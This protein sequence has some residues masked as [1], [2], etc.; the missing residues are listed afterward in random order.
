MLF[1]NNKIRFERILIVFLAMLFLLFMT[2]SV[3]ASENVSYDMNISD[4]YDIENN[5]GYVLNEND[6][7][8][9]NSTQYYGEDRVYESTHV[10]YSSSCQKFTSGKIEYNVKLYDFVR[11]GGVRYIEPKY[12]SI[13]KLKV[14][15]GNHYKNYQARVS[16]DGI[17]HIKIP[18]LNIGLHKVEIYHDNVKKGS[19]SIKIIKSVAKVYGPAKFI[20]YGK[21]AYMRV[22][23]SYGRIVKNVLLKVNVSTGNKVKT[24]RIRTDNGGFASFK[25]D[26]LSY[27]R[28][29]I[30]ITTADSRYV[31][32]KATKILVKKTVQK[33]PKKLYAIAN[34]VTNQYKHNAYFEIRV[35]DCYYFA[36]KNLVLKMKIFTD[37]KY[38]TV[39]LK[40]NS[41]GIAR[42]NTKALSIGSHKIDISNVNKKYI[43]NKYSK[44]I[45]KRNIGFKIEPTKLKL[46]T[47]SPNHYIKLTWMSKPGSTYQI[48][49]KSD[50]DYHIVSTV[51]AKSENQ[52]FME[53]VDN[54]ILAT[55][56]VRELITNGNK[57]I[58]GSWDMGGLKMIDSPHVD[59]DFQNL[60]AKIS[61][62]AIGGAT[63]YKIL[64]KI[65]F[66]GEYSCIATV[67]SKKLTYTDWYY[68]SPDKLSQLLNKETF[69]DPNS[70]NLFY[71]VR[72]CKIQKINDVQKSSMGLY[73]KDGDFHL[74]SPTI[75]HI[76]ENNITWGEVLNA[77]G[78][79][80]LKKDN[81]NGLWEKIAEVN[82]TNSVV[83]SFEIGEVD[84]DAYYSV[85]AFS[86]KNG[87]LIR[88]G[89]DKGFT[90]KYFSHNSTNKILFI[91]DSITHGSPYRYLYELS[92][93]FSFPYRVSQLTGCTFY[94]PSVAGSTYHDLGIKSDGSNV[95][96]RCSIPREVMDP[97]SI[98]QLPARWKKEGTAKNSEGISH[99]KLSDYNIVVLSAG[100][101]DY[102][103]NSKLG[104]INT[105]DTFYFN[106][107][108]NYI[109]NLIKNASKY[110]VSMGLSPIKVVFMDLFLS[111]L[112]KPY[113]TPI[114]RD[115]SPNSMGLTLV[116]YQKELD[117]QFYKWSKSDLE[118]FKFKT[119]SYNIVNGNN[120][121]HTTADNQHF[122]KF[123]YGQY[124][125]ELTKFLVENVFA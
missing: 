51:I 94:N 66:E 81:E 48:L 88:S 3:C 123:T 19:S 55:Y 26:G 80:I 52:F 41:K 93:I 83:Q 79:Y 24:Y 59:V 125:N 61:W 73:L 23:D 54:K 58:V 49:K 6:L 102:S 98:G 22:I 13:I 20:K 37:N 42:Y 32:Y 57:N 117:K 16:D 110:R 10:K 85:Q 8:E 14:Y 36:V 4:S 2:G 84:N 47:Y 120:Y 100:L 114:N 75:V 97:I 109:M 92:G 17:A 76:K 11:Y 28:H 56:S 46:L 1:G 33:H 12:G 107:G 106:G 27:G 91:G 96:K 30:V 101:N 7:G 122:T 87:E 89:Y 67:D 103:D 63:K 39:T 99:T 60:K 121:M 45:I 113:Y 5:S 108:I 25:V 50:G 18:N 31:F 29:K 119:R 21:T 34:T 104:S 112:K 62:N 86:I 70:N 95:N 53:K 90:L 44:I 118:V 35:N 124:G 115:T 64:R 116:D 15:T 111:N 78:Y 9:N 82:N 69:I 71:T 65:G 105:K 43:L 77:K 74:E 72:A 68:K 40:T 38:K